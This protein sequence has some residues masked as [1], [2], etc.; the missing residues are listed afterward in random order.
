[1]NNK[2]YKF[3]PKHI[4]G[5]LF[6]PLIGLVTNP[7]ALAKTLYNTIRSF[8]KNGISCYNR[9]S[10]LN[11]IN[12]LF[13]YTQA[14]NLKKYGKS[15]VCPHI[16]KGNFKLRN[17]FHISGI[18]LKLYFLSG[19][20]IPVLSLFL[21]LFSNSI[22]FLNDIPIHHILIVLLLAVISSL[23]FANS[24]FLQNYNAIAWIS[25]PIF[26]FALHT[27]NYSLIAISLFLISIG[28]I[29]ALV[30][31]IILLFALFI[32]TLDLN[33]FYTIIPSFLWLLYHNR[34]IIINKDFDFI[35]NII[36]NIGFKK[37]NV[38][39]I[40]ER[41]KLYLLTDIYFSFLFLQYY[42][43][44]YFTNNA[45]NYI[46][47]SAVIIF[48]LNSFV[49]RFAD[50]QSMYMLFLSITTYY[51]ITE[52]NI[53]L[54]VSYWLAISPIPISLGL[55]YIKNKSIFTLPALKPFNINPI[56]TDMN[57]FLQD[58]K[59]GEKILFAFDNP[60]KDYSKIFDGYRNL[61][62]PAL[63]VASNKEIHLIP[64][65]YFIIDTNFEGAPEYWGRDVKNV[66]ENTKKLNASYVI[67]YQETGTK[68]DPKWENSGFQIISEYDWKNF[69]IENNY[70]NPFNSTIPKWWLLKVQV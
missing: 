16:G 62:E 29:T 8:K 54:L 5:I 35:I 56:V 22:W 30:I 70:I 59:E 51:T 11:G 37:A 48:I 42:I 58:V 61:I 44:L 53:F 21:W 36:G 64:D 41:N 40:R 38:K 10:T 69:Y 23:F 47:L 68:I 45:A 57:V 49:A 33:L 65:W 12:S 32:K 34:G 24:F 39:Y 26:L 3:K 43:I 67:I 63:Y 66:Q 55:T 52:Y 19:A 9:F 31:S 20:L 7:F 60:Q 6:Y 18:E 17:W 27:A 25:F 13:Y 50:R 28:G 15:G 14:V 4:F 1:M 46:Y 2:I